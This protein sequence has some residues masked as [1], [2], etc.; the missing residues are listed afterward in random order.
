MPLFPGKGV[1]S[2]P[3][4][5]PFF[6]FVTRKLAYHLVCSKYF[7]NS[8][9]CF[10]IYNINQLKLYIEGI[11]ISYCAPAIRCSTTQYIGKK[12]RLRTIPKKRLH[13]Q[14]QNHTNIPDYIARTWA[15][16]KT[17]IEGPPMSIILYTE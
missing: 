11:Q 1:A 10:N 2:S 6:I 7:D 3:L 8:P 16:Y 12:Q 13:D 5:G 9:N 14:P 15:H 17:I 4:F